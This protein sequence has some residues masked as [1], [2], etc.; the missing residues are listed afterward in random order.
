MQS[1]LRLTLC[2]SLVVGSSLA[3]ARIVAAETKDGTDRIDGQCNHILLLLEFFDR[4]TPTG[5]AYWMVKHDVGD[6]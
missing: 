4:V 3:L 6:I 2:L 5:V 1:R